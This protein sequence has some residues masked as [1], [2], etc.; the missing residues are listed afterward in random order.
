METDEEE[1]AFKY[2]IWPWNEWESERLHSFYG[3]R[4]YKHPRLKTAQNETKMALEEQEEEEGAKKSRRAVCP[5]TRV[6][7]TEAKGEKADEEV[8]KEEEK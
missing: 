3:R 7:E 5:M 4:E 1:E 2:R 6:G 8:K